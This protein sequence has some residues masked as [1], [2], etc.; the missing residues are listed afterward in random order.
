MTIADY[1]RQLKL[2]HDP[3]IAIYGVWGSGILEGY[4]SALRRYD[5]INLEFAEAKPVVS[6]RIKENIS[7]P[8]RSPYAVLCF[9]IDPDYFVRWL[10]R[11]K[12]VSCF[13]AEEWT[14]RQRNTEQ[15]SKIREI[16]Q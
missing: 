2:A 3:Y 12:G 1:I 9:R 13:T 11:E 14:L 4:F 8:V 7:D 16:V 15:K 6:K 10:R 5:F